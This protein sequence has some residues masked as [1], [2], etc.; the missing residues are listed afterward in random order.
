MVF[1]DLFWNLVDSTADCVIAPSLAL[2]LF[3][4][5]VCV[6]RLHILLLPISPS[7]EE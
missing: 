4:F 1:L 7:L 6:L 5:L 3:F 2:E